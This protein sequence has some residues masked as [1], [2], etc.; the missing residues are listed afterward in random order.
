MRYATDFHIFADQSKRYTMNVLDILQGKQQASI[1]EGKKA[2][3]TE[4]SLFKTELENIRETRRSNFANN[5][6]WILESKLF[7]IKRVQKFD[8]SEHTGIF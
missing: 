4:F 3:I 1:L 8:A 5:L 7:N 2:K 6:I